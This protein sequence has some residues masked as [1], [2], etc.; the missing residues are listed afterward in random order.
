MIMM[1][2]SENIKSM[3]DGLESI[4]ELE[5][6]IE[7]D[8]SE[9]ELFEK[10]ID[11]EEMFRSAEDYFDIEALEHSMEQLEI[12]LQCIAYANKLIQAMQA[13]Q[14]GYRA[15]KRCKADSCLASFFYALYDGCNVSYLI[16]GGCWLV[17]GWS[18]WYF[19]ARLKDD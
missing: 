11:T 4:E 12:R 1:E 15:L 3:Y 8:E 19:K 9:I 13:T 7:V 16:G 2:L 18:L 10:S 17:V 5:Y 6:A 14:W